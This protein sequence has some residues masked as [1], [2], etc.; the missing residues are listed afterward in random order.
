MAVTYDTSADD[1][2]EDVATATTAAMTVA[3][4]ADRYAIL[5]VMKND[6]ATTIDSA[7]FDSVSMTSLLAQYSTPTYTWHHCRNYELV[8][9]GSGASKT[10]VGTIS[11]STDRTYA[12]AIVLNGV[13]QTTPKNSTPTPTTG[14]FEDPTFTGSASITVTT[15]TNGKAVGVLN[16]TNTGGVNV[17]VTGTGGTT[18]RTV[19]NFSVG[20]LAI[21]E[22][23][24]NAGSTV[25]SADLA[26]T[27]GNTGWTIHAWGIQP[28]AAAG[29]ATLSGSAGTSGHG[30]QAPVFSI[31]L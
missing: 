11:A 14:L 4:T 27:A 29:G 24:D 21:L 25:L 6:T 12:A 17:T 15:V 31:G 19:E 20:T 13:H 9:P 23:D 3:S 2:Q 16:I 10:G 30:T 26:T 28:S 18:V 1:H 7:V 5:A 8:N 22:R